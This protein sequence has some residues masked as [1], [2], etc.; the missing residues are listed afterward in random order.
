MTM[1]SVILAALLLSP[2]LSIAVAHWPVRSSARRAQLMAMLVL[3]WLALLAC[4]LVTED[5]HHQ[6]ILVMLWAIVFGPAVVVALI[7]L[8]VA[9]VGPGSEVHP[10]SWGRRIRTS[11]M[12]GPGRAAWVGRFRRVQGRWSRALLGAGFS[13]VITAFVEA[14]TAVPNQH[15][16]GWI[17][18]AA[19]NLVVG[20]PLI[21]AVLVADRGRARRPA[22][23]L[24]RSG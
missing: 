8:L 18:V 6:E 3:G 1:N 4:W 13:M 14:L 15:S 2:A 22:D 17:V 23:V 10:W 19:L 24:E 9:V 20:L 21:V 16:P 5:P 7:R 11:L 12:A